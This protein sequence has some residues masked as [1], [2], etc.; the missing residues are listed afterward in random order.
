MGEEEGPTST[1]STSFLLRHLARDVAGG[2]NALAT[3]DGIADGNI[4][5]DDDESSTSGSRTTRADMI[6]TLCSMVYLI[7]NN[8]YERLA[9]IF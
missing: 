8:N 3:D 9:H 7:R 5:D 6:T 4:D 1:S 2:E